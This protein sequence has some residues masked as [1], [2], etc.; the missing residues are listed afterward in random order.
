MG[1]KEKNMSMNFCAPQKTGKNVKHIVLPPVNKFKTAINWKQLSLPEMQGDSV[2]LSFSC[3][4]RD[5][6]VVLRAKVILG[7]TYEVSS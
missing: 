3:V 7:H 2:M 6:R 5:L 4:S 1:K